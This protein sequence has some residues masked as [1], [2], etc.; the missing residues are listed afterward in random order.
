MGLCSSTGAKKLTYRANFLLGNPG[1]IQPKTIEELEEWIKNLQPHPSWPE[2]DILRQIFTYDVSLIPEADIKASEYI[3]DTWEGFLQNCSN[4]MLRNWVKVYCEGLGAGNETL[5][6]ELR[7]IH[8]ESCLESCSCNGEPNT[9]DVSLVTDM[10]DLFKDMKKFNAPIDQWNTSQV[11]DMNGM[12]EGASSF[13]QPITMDTSKVTDMSY[14]F[15][16]ATSFNQPITMDT[17]QVTDMTYMF[18]GATEM[19]YPLPDPPHN[20]P[21]LP[22]SSVVAKSHSHYYLKCSDA[23]TE[24]FDDDK[25][26]YG[27]FI[28]Y[29]VPFENWSPDV[30]NFF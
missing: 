23:C 13:N 30:S 2:E 4:A 1:G 28:Q 19:T 22:A 17:S 10:K 27:T 18:Y 15:R 25:G 9:W 5:T 16:G 6:D 11:T 8:K 26:N 29:C 7:A 21:P 12:F 3:L 20:P 14:M 24:Y